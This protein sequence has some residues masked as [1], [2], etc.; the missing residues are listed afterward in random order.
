MKYKLLTEEQTK[1][2]IRAMG[3][4]YGV[5]ADA[6]L[7][8]GVPKPGVTAKHPSGA[9]IEIEVSDFHDAQQLINEIR[10]IDDTILF[11]KYKTL[12]E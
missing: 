7:I 8:G 2:I 3:S 10:K 1:Q 6:I 5:Y 4:G 12:F 11:E 9:R